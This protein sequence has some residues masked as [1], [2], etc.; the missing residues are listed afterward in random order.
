MSM[1]QDEEPPTEKGITEPTKRDVLL[2]RGAACWNH[3]GNKWFRTIVAANIDKYENCKARVEKML[4]VSDIVSQIFENDGRF[5]KKD[6]TSDTWHTVDRK[7]AIEKT[8]HAIRDKRAVEQK[9][10]HKE[11]MA[12][13]FL[14]HA[15]MTFAAGGNFDAG[16][17]NMRYAGIDHRLS[18]VHDD[19]QRGSAEFGYNSRQGLLQPGNGSFWSV[20]LEPPPSVAAQGVLTLGSPYRGAQ[21][22]GSMLGRSPPHRMLREQSSRDFFVSSRNT[23]EALNTIRRRAEMTQSALMKLREG[24]SGETSLGDRWPSERSTSSILKDLKR[25]SQLAST[26]AVERQSHEGLSALSTGRPTTNYNQFS[27]SFDGR[28]EQSFRQLPSIDRGEPTIA[29]DSETQAALRK[30]QATLGDEETANAIRRASMFSGASIQDRLPVLPGVRPDDLSRKNAWDSH[31]QLPGGVPPTAAY[32]AWKAEH[33]AGEG[34]ANLGAGH[35]R[36]AD[37]NDHFGES[38]RGRGI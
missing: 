24:S 33:L 9:R 37:Y 13:E 8:G 6:A 36:F 30:L 34:P 2:G 20:Y 28:D 3:S 1:S 25:A 31:V 35:P 17:G 21:D 7:S 4:I 26:I 16:G 32:S 18:D 29:F 15:N 12:R 23:E 38:G 5:L 11:K 19:I 10:E 22:P 14:A 27:F